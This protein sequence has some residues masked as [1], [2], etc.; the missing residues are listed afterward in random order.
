MKIILTLVFTTIVGFVNAQQDSTN[1]NRTLADSLGA[2]A[3]GMKAYTLVIL[4]TGSN[5]TTEKAFIDSMF[6]GHL[7]NIGKLAK[8]GKL[9]LAGPILKKNSNQYRGIF[10]LN[11]KTEADAKA[12][13][14]TDPAIIANLL[15][16]EMYSWYGSAALPMFLP[17]HSKIAKN[18]P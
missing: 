2:D 9:V 17:Y 1:Y 4:K 18:N 7:N 12:L 3:Y 11:A 15:E 13:L 16:P 5:T 8:E 10:I 14:A 6:R